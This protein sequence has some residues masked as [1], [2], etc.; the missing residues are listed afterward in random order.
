[1]LDVGCGE[2]ADA[3][4]LASQGWQV[5]ALDI[6]S[7]ALDRTRAAAAAAGVEVRLVHAGVVEAALSGFDVVSAFYPALLTTPGRDAERALM[8]ATA[9]G[10][11]LLFVHH[12]PDRDHARSHGFDLDDYV[13]VADMH[14]ALDDSWTVLTYQERA[15]EISGGSGA[16]HRVDVVLI[17]RRG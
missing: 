13:S 16:H 1:M 4:W 9:P 2:G 17:A 6:S 12:V 11:T 3:V 7:V 10:G 15:R 5:T 14:A 8:A